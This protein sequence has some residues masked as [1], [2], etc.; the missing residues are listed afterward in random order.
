MTQQCKSGEHSFRTY[1]GVNSAVGTA[2]IKHMYD[3]YTQDPEYWLKIGKLFRAVV[4]S[5]RKISR[6]QTKVLYHS[7]NMEEGPLDTPLHNLW[8]VKTKTRLL[9]HNKCP[10]LQSSE[11]THLQFHTNLTTSELT[12]TR[13][14]LPSLVLSLQPQKPQP[15][16]TI[17]TLIIHG[18]RASLHPWTALS[19]WGV[20]LRFTRT[21]LCTEATDLLI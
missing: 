2:Q 5:S 17:P 20:A 19:V 10:F 8:W 11:R 13:P 18:S 16:S 12:T 21:H 15:T 7:S 4:Q 9:T 3:S 6:H 1:K 14:Q